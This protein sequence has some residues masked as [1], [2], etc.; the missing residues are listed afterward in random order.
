MKLLLSFFFTC[1]TLAGYS[2]ASSKDTVHVMLDTLTVTAPAGPPVYRGAAAKIWEIKSTRIALSFDLKEKTAKVKEWIRLHPYFY[3]ADSLV[4]DA[5]SMRIDSVLLIGKKGNTPVAFSYKNDELRIRF[6]RT[7]QSTDSIELY[8]VYTAMPYASA[9]EGS[10]SITDDRGL[11]FINTD[12]SVPHKPA[13]IWTQG[14]TESNSHWM[15]TIDK[16]N[17]RFATQIELTVPDSFTTL[18][19]GALI[20]QTKDKHGLRTDIWKMNTPIQA[21][22][23]MFAIGKFSVIK[24]HWRN[25][26]VSYYV[27]PGYAPYA[28]LI[29]NHTPEMMEFFSQ[30][31]GVPYPWNKYS[32][33]VVRDYVSG[34]MENTSAS[35]FGEFMNATARELA[36]R[37]S[38]DVVSHEL[39]H[40]WFGDYVTAKSWSNL[41][42]NES[43]ANYGEQL[44]R[45][46]KRGKAS[47]DSLAFAD[48]QGY[49]F[50]SQLNDP[51]L[52]RFNYDNREDMFDAVSYNKGGEILR[53][54]NSLIGDAAF[55]RAM[56]LYLTQN[57]LH[58]AE[59]QSWRMAVEEA[60][61]QDWNWFFNEWYYHPGHPQ[62][63]VTYD[64]N[65]TAQKLTVTVSQAQ[66]DSTFMYVLPLKAAIIYGND[67]RVV[68]W[69]I[70]RK[71]ETFVYPYEQGVAP[72]I[73]PD[74]TH[75][76]PGELRDNKKSQQWLVQMMQADDY[77]S[78]RL[79][80]GSAI[81]SMSDSASQALIDLALNDR[82][83]GIRRFTLSQL[84]D[85]Q[86]EKYHRRWTAKVSYMATNDA[87]RL[88]RAEAINV[89][90]DWK[91]EAMKPQIAAAIADSSYAIAGAALD[92]LGKF[93]KDTAYLA[94]KAMVRTNPRAALET[95]VWSA[96]GKKGND[97]DIT[98]FEEHAPYV[99]GSGKFTFAASLSRYL[100]NVK[101]ESSFSRG[102]DVYVSLIMSESLKN[103]YTMLSG[104]LFQLASEFS[105][106]MKS[107]NKEE[108]ENARK[109]LPVIKAGIERIIVTQKDPEVV[110][111]LKKRMKDT[112]E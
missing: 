85:V 10:I 86:S 49:I 61:G 57:A 105:G 40:Q 93:D 48:L 43:F 45:A 33:V 104:Y 87:D 66:S 64:Y 29:F 11:Y 102:V 69:N 15:A 98:L 56:K 42:V 20:K 110:K 62:L 88:V 68:D 81:R 16:P 23:V 108:A 32:Q 18:S 92:A 109:R 112:F 90:G 107:D 26:E 17:T 7:Y 79:A 41:T 89:L 12:Y 38:E 106:N 53:Y 74:C 4:L 25:K 36:D 111:D 95:A 96:V 97:A 65:D 99:S 47:A 28:R 1:Y 70:S 6:G 100:K 21:Y 77:I 24:D 59:A 76:L 84:K 50:S 13:E 54:L 19:N 75:V 30:R 37:N 103:Y 5:K 35:L 31:T 51:Q 91:V 60:T 63:R 46:Y 80:A 55:D 39:F 2:R 8:L 52:V 101:S 73:I 14:E 22:A 34:A 3:A 72:V 44:W 82:F 83:A 9:S 94:A 67:K 71:K 27:E 78:R 58:S